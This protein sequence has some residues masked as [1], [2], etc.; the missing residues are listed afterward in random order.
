MANLKVPN[1]CGASPEFNAVQSK[2]ESL[3]SNA[4]GGL[5]SSASSL[6]STMGTDITSLETELR[7]LVPQLPALPNVNLQSQ[8]T[9]LS[10]LTPGSFE[11][12]QLLADITTD[13]GTEL[14]AGGYTLDTLVTK[15]LAEIQGGGDLCSAVPN[16]ELPAAGGTAKEKSV[17][18]KQATID[19]EEEKKSTVVK[20]LPWL[21][22]QK[23]NETRVA[24]MQVEGESEDADV[25]KGTIT[26]T[27]PPTESTGAYK[28]TDDSSKVTYDGN[29]IEVT[30]PAEQ[31][32]K[33]IS[34]KGLAKRKAKI[35]EHF[36]LTAVGGRSAPEAVDPV[37]GKPW[38]VEPG[39]GNFTVDLKH[40]PIPDSVRFL[41]NFVKVK[42]VRVEKAD[43]NY[44]VLENT[45]V[46]RFLLAPKYIRN[47]QPGTPKTLRERK[48]DSIFSV[49]T[50]PEG[51]E[52]QVNI[53]PMGEIFKPHTKTNNHP[54]Y[55]IPEREG[56][57]FVI[58]YS[59][60]ENYDPGLVEVK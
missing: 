17:E 57:I 27:T 13:F 39:Q 5:D 58:T 33:N 20:N 11:H 59:Y 16:F 2:F 25:V 1:L 10:D 26:A 30:T 49:G 60:F 34:T 51:T 55:F 15:A 56:V 19:S 23:E 42:S 7:A 32:R 12:T 24:S 14:T 41:A 54:V 43:G 53:M 4:L 52:K 38:D 22:E 37:T 6:S 3:I 47:K 40:I 35:T 50:V 21:E 31:N 9:S 29:A 46:Q 36:K 45:T 48:T 18:S 44:E 28:V 8:I